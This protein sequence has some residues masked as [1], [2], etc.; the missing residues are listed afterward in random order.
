M[1]NGPQL[2]VSSQENAL[3][4][5]IMDSDLERLE[6]L[7]VQFNLFDVLGI[8]RREV[9]HSKFIAW[10]LDPYGSH[11]LGDYFLRGFLAQAAAYGRER[12]ISDFTPFDVD[13]WKFQDIEVATERHH[14]DILV[15]DE[16]DGFVCLIENK[17]GGAEH[18][19]QLSNYLRTVEH[20]Y[21][22]LTAFPIF[23]TPDG[24]EPDDDDDADRLSYHF[25]LM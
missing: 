18:S 14:I 12:G 21:E 10:L 8:A 11:G 5:L 15:I 17:I 2:G 23:L 24:A 16:S 9:Q 6:D 3:Q 7:L 25:I 22:G 20:E 1:T 4:T 13:S 19:S